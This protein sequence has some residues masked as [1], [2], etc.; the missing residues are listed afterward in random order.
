MRKCIIC[1]ESY[2]DQFISRFETLNNEKQ[3]IQVCEHC[4]EEHSEYDDEKDLPY[5][6]IGQN[7]YPSAQV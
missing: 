7:Y 3:F 6:H 2:D 4:N 5:I 1:K